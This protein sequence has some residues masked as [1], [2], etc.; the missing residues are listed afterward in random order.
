MS[1]PLPLGTEG[2]DYIGWL[3]ALHIVLCATFG[4]GFPSLLRH[5]NQRTDLS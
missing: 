4:Q 2:F 3:Y 5:Q 1:K